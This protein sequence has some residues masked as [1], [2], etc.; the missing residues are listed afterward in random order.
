MADPAMHP[1]AIDLECL[2]FSSPK[3]ELTKEYKPVL[4]LHEDGLDLS[5]EVNGN[6]L[7]VTIDRGYLSTELVEE[8]LSVL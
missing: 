4:V 5:W 2:K 7:A 3:G 6:R 8:I 1:V